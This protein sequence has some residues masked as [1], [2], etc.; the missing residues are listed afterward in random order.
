M[1]EEK[2]LKDEVLDDEK[3]EQ[4]SGGGPRQTCGDNDLMIMLGLTHYDGTMMVNISGDDAG[5]IVKKGW[6]QV[7]IRMVPGATIFD[8]NKYFLGINKLSRKEAFIHALKESGWSD[9]KIL[10]KF[11]FDSVKGDW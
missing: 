5:I 8:D 3:L 9:D 4:V 1:S 11:D 2:I 6:A 7:G 10:D